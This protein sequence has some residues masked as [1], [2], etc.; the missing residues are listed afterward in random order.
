[1]TPAQPPLVARLVERIGR[2]ASVYAASSAASLALALA[3]L[4][5][6][7]QFLAPGEFARLAIL[8]VFASLLTVVYNLGSLQGTLNLVFGS[9]G[10]HEAR[11]E[12]DLDDAR[13]R[14]VALGT[15]LLLT[16]GAAALGTLA[17]AAAAIP[18]ADLLGAG[19]AVES[20]AVIMAAASGGL[21]ST[22]RFTT[23]VLRLERRPLAYFAHSVARP[24]LVV[25]AVAPAVASGWGVT[26][27]IGGVLAG[28]AAASAIGLATVAPRV[29]LAFSRALAGRLMRVGAPFAA[30]I[31]SFWTIQNVDL[32]LLSRFAAA[33][34]VAEYRV[35]TR[36]ASVSAYLTSAFLMAWGPLRLS[37]LGIAVERH[38]GAT[39]R[40]FVLLY[41]GLA[42][43]WVLL[44]VALA[45]EPVAGLFPQ[46]YGISPALVVLVAGGSVASGAVVVVYRLAG[47]PGGRRRYAKVVVGAAALFLCVALLLVPALGAAGAGLSV[48]AAFAAATAMLL[49]L[50]RRGERAVPL[51]APR[52]AAAAALAVALW[53]GASRVDGVALVPEA[54]ALLA[55]PALLVAVGVVPRRHARPAWRVIRRLARRGPGEALSLDGADPGD[56]L[57]FELVIRDRLDPAAAAGRAG[58]GDADAAA[59]AVVRALRAATGI[60]RTEEADAS[61]PEGEAALDARLGAYLLA[62]SSVADRDA[63]G[64]RLCAS[65]VDPVELYMLEEALAVERRRSR[66]RPADA[67]EP[68]IA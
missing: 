8:L 39:L 50:A 60:G 22:W 6:L 5:L 45:A 56:A 63:I 26:G 38:H 40:R 9:D 2:H 68:S 64:R 18:L 47:V 10:D 61:A 54:L 3:N 19:G 42:A 16:A 59:A 31:L 14:R 52:M 36:L 33:G 28:T 17:V 12:A 66:R 37:A 67:S 53:A 32:F 1:M 25:A 20:R 29:D 24:L 11:D 62:D 57:A 46:A 51:A 7:T 48:I 15:G 4:A 65:G 55:F 13:D 27:A 21:A 43:T 35:A 58:L 30:V 41:Y 34:E 23:N 44:A 49:W